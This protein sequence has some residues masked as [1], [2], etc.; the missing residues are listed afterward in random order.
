MKKL[1]IYIDTSVVG[2]CLD[3]EFRKT[4]C[5]L[6]EMARRG[7]I[8]LLISD[9]LRAELERAPTEIQ[10]VITDLPDESFEMTYASQETE[11][12]R[13]HYLQSGV[14][15]DASLNDAHHVAIASVSG[16]DL[17][18]S[19]NFKHL[20]HFVKIRGFNSVNLREGYNMIHICS[21]LEV[22]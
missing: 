6:F 19:W 16:A 8:I 18:V 14:V 4:S 3:Q 20:V 13:N 17:V 7:E 10:K 2:G 12:L 15:G 21:P 22:V 1:R 5:E 9:L 11:N